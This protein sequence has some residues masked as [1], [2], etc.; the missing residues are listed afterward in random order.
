[1]SDLKF[2]YQSIINV[3]IRSI[4]IIAAIIVCILK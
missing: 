1:M 4:I 2:N 3:I